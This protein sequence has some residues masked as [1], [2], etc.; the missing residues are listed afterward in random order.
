MLANRQLPHPAL[1]ATSFGGTDLVEQIQKDLLN[2]LLSSDRIFCIV[3]KQELGAFA[4]AK[5]SQLLQDRCCNVTVLWHC[6]QR[7]KSRGESAR[8]YGTRMT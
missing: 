6:G 2:I 8:V 3:N 4:Q 5:L 1:I 7:G